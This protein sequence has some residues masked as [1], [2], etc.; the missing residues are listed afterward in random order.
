MSLA[1][2][3]PAPFS[4]KLWASTANCCR[5]PPLAS[6]INFWPNL[7]LFCHF[8]PLWMPNWAPQTRVPGSITRSSLFPHL[9]GGFLLLAAPPRQLSAVF[10]LPSPL[11]LPELRLQPE[12]VSRTQ[13]CLRVF[14]APNPLMVGQRFSNQ[15][16]GAL[17]SL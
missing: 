9:V 17:R 16:G 10:S 2:H 13:P 1:S 11:P 3:S 14:S 4:F 15:A 12:A 8:P 5:T 7:F 6:W